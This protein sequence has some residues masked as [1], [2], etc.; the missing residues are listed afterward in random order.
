M[1]CVG[2]GKLDVLFFRMLVFL[3]VI[4]LSEVEA[5]SYFDLSDGD[6]RF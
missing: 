2:S 3:C 5:D 4:F 1:D 6:S